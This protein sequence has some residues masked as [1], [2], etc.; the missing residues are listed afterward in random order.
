MPVIVRALAKFPRENQP[1]HRAQRQCV[2][3]VGEIESSNRG[4]T[5]R[6][7]G[8]VCVTA[9]RVPACVPA[10]SLTSPSSLLSGTGPALARVPC[11]RVPGLPVCVIACVSC[12][13]KRSSGASGVERERASLSC[14]LSVSPS[15]VSDSEREADGGRGRDALPGAAVEFCFFPLSFSHSLSRVSRDVCRLR[16]QLLSPSPSLPLSPTE[17]V[18]SRRRR[19]HVALQLW[20]RDRLAARVCSIL[21]SQ[22]E[23]L[24]SRIWNSDPQ[25]SFSLSHSAPAS[26]A[27]RCFAAAAALLRSHSLAA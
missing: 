4:L 26:F 1:R 23:S 18:S 8:C 11:R 24:S 22:R 21:L 13:R 12:K 19:A 3:R 5:M 15:C 27:A 17:T 14:G 25:D 10:S 9:G 2:S 16:Q 7:R 6:F 20:G